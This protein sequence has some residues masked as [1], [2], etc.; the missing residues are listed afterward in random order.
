M[1]ANLNSTTL[2]VIMPTKGEDTLLRAINSVLPQLKEGDELLIV[3]DGD[4]GMN[5]KAEIEQVIDN[6]FIKYWETEKTGYWGNHQRNEALKIAKGDYIIFLDADDW[7]LEGALDKIK[8]SVSKDPK[9]V[10][11]FAI[12]GHSGYVKS[13]TGAWPLVNLPIGNGMVAL[14][15]VKEWLVEYG[16]DP[17]ETGGDSD[18]QMIRQVIANSGALPIHHLILTYAEG[19]IRGA[20]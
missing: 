7:Y 16:T 10:H 14:P 1:E 12:Q 11:S 18:W 17:H 13:M 9:R 2:S 5:R 15:N 8:A 3:V 20:G 19:G 6:P 4:I